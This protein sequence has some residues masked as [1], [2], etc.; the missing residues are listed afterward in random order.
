MHVIDQGQASGD[1]FPVDPSGV[2]T[3]HGT[4]TDINIATGLIGLSRS[5][6]LI[7]D[8]ETRQNRK[9]TVPDQPS[10]QIHSLSGEVE[11][12]RGDI[13]MR[14][15]GTTD[16]RSHHTAI[17]PAIEDQMSNSGWGGSPPEV[18]P[19]QRE[20]QSQTVLVRSQQLSSAFRNIYY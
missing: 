7:G 8:Q 16:D 2:N 20:P 17:E 9:A 15:F 11:P 4:E 1:I 13:D 18:I 14:N 10:Y 3:Y 19:Q 12:L 5:H 6:P